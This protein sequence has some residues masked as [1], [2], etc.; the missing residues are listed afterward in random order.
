MQFVT[1]VKLTTLSTYQKTGE[2][3][4]FLDH[5][6]AGF[7]L[8][9][10]KS[11]HPV[12]IDTCPA[13]LHNNNYYQ[14]KKANV[15]HCP[16]LGA[17][18]KNEAYA[19]DIITPPWSSGDC[20]NQT[21]TLRQP[22]TTFSHNTVYASQSGEL[23]FIDKKITLEALPDELA[24]IR[25]AIDSALEKTKHTPTISAQTVPHQTL[26]HRPAIDAKLLKPYEIKKS[27]EE[28]KHDYPS[29]ICNVG[30]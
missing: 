21:I 17:V 1:L 15:G 12:Q 3:K 29:E 26:F 24:E 14:L 25:P 27:E 10:A 5:I 20:S 6:H 2:E 22:T 19:A 8:A 23:Y 4:Y 11:T 16:N 18:A 28:I 7:Q 30:Y 9:A 13:L